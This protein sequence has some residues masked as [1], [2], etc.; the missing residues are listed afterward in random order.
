MSRNSRDDKYPPKIVCS[1]VAANHCLYICMPEKSTI[2]NMEERMNDVPF[3]TPAKKNSLSQY[4]SE[5][6]PFTYHNVIERQ[7]NNFNQKGLILQ[8]RFYT[9]M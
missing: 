9:S 3:P 4:F 2:A 5:N 6:K 7:V 1:A 8:F